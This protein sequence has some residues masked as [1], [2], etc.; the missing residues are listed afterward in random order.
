MKKILTFV[1]LIALVISSFFAYSPENILAKSLSDNPVIILSGKLN[2]DNTLTIK[3]NLTSN[4][5]ISA[6]TFELVYDKEV[7]TLISVEMG[8]ALSSLDPMTTN[9]NTDEGYSITPFIFNYIGKREN[10]YSTGNMFT[11]TFAID[12]IKEDGNYNVSLSYNRNQDVNYIDESGELRTKN[13]FIDSAEIEVKN[14]EIIQ[15]STIKDKDKPTSDTGR[16]IFVSLFVV[17]MIATIVVIYI[18]K[19]RKL[20]KYE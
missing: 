6:M 13:L 8:K 17:S 10:D 20:K 12:E 2:P 19:S 9:T 1:L 18:K 14:N 7:M 4:S 5:G 15:V 16:I 11:L 3:A